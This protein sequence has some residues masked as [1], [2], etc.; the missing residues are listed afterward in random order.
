MKC[1][2]ILVT[3]FIGTTA[4]RGQLTEYGV[5]SKGWTKYRE[6]GALGFTR[7]S[8]EYVVNQSDT[9]F[10]LLMWDQRPEI[11]SYFSVT[12]SSQGK[13]LSGLYGILLSFFEKDNW[14]KK[15]YIR[16][17]QLGNEKV[18]VYQSGMIA[19]KAI[20]FSTEKGRIQFTKADVEKLL[21]PK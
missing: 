17:F 3:V 2:L 9:T 18:S 13:T 6:L 7:A 10:L 20:I 4:A 21:G 12:F 5:S 11:K 15:D 8:L 16:L 19:P 1:L 14:R